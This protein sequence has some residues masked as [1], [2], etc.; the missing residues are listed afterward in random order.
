MSVERAIKNRSQLRDLRGGVEL[1]PNQ[2]KAL[3]AHLRFI[4]QEGIT[5]NE[6]HQRAIKCVSLDGSVLTKAEQLTGK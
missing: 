6:A 2:E 3:A 4:L 1:S 5:F